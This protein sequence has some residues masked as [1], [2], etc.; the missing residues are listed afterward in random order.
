MTKVFIVSLLF[1]LISG[2]DLVEE[3]EHNS[4][5]GKIT[6]F[7]SPATNTEGDEVMG[8]F[9][10]TEKIY[11][12]GGYK[13]N[14]DAKFEDNMLTVKV[15]GIMPPETIAADSLPATAFVDLKNMPRSWGLC[16]K[17]DGF[18]DMYGV[19]Y[20]GNFR[21]FGP[22]TSHTAPYTREVRYY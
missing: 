22:S 10:Q 7:V 11:K 21:I 3:D 2:C 9:F 12:P 18:S 5:Y 4:E 19:N 1:I 8:L 15:K 13:I 17:G 20:I 6:F 14:I 16:I